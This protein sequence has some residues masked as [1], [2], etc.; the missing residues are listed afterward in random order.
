MIFSAAAAKA[1]PDT[2]APAS[3]EPILPLVENQPP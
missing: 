2:G 1:M 3:A